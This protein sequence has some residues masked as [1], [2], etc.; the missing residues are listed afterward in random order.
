MK[1]LKKIFEMDNK[2]LQQWLDKVLDE[3]NEN[4]IKNK[5]IDKF[6]KAYSND[7]IVELSVPRQPK[8]GESFWSL[9]SDPHA[10]EYM[11]KDKKGIWYNLDLDSIDGEGEDD[12]YYRSRENNIRNYF[13]KYPELRS[14]L[15]EL[16]NIYSESEKKMDR[17]KRE[18]RKKYNNDYGL[19]QKIDYCK[20]TI[21]LLDQFGIRN[22]GN[23][24]GDL[25]PDTDI[26]K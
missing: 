2:E 13:K 22:Y 6:L 24:D 19:M 7:E 12:R 26:I 10:N 1:H 20:G 4:G 14:E 18:M 25:N 15:I 23:D 21:S 3:I 8:K 5:T 17:L 16:F 9:M 11:W